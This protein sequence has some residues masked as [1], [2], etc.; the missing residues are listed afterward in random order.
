MGSSMMKT[1][2]IDRRYQSIKD[3]KQGAFAKDFGKNE[4]GIRPDKGSTIKITGKKTK[5]QEPNPYETQIAARMQPTD[6]SEVPDGRQA[7]G[8]PKMTFAS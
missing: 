3:V 1:Q 4:A 2:G 6:P 7:T 5:Y 8:F